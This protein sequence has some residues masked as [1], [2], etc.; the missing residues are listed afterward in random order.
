MVK[1]A[2]PVEERV[3]LLRVA[4]VDGVALG[5]RRQSLERR[6]DA[7][8]LLDAT[9]TVAPSAAACS[10]VARPIP[11]VPPKITIR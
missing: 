7:V 6:V 4:N 9:I 1:A 11:D 2:Q 3:D 10:A 8:R 5:A